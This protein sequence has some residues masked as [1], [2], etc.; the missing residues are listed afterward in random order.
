MRSP[1]TLSATAAACATV[2][3]ALLA[4]PTPVVRAQESDEADLSRDENGVCVSS[5]EV[6]DECAPAAD[7]AA[8]FALVGILA[9]VMLFMFLLVCFIRMMRLKRAKF[10]RRMSLEM[11]A[12]DVEAL[13]DPM[14]AVAGTNPAFAGTMTHKGST[15]Q[16][17]SASEVSKVKQGF[18][19]ALARLKSAS[20]AAQCL[21]ALERLR[22]VLSADNVGFRDPV[23]KKRLIETSKVVR[24]NNEALWTPEVAS[25]FG[26]CIM[27]F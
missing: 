12:L 20:S 13:D 26:S 7:C 16:A 6:N 8:A 5:C 3:I 14:P 22:A 9:G 10:T 2:V 4:I 11:E 18:D 23:Q 24:E 17:G 27:L 1:A 15:A 25:A 21:E 19:A